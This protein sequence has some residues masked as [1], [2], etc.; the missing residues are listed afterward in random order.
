MILLY[1]FRS[2]SVGV[3]AICSERHA[4]NA[5]AIPR[6]HLS[7]QDCCPDVLVKDKFLK[8]NFGEISE[9][10]PVSIVVRSHLIVPH[11]AH[12]DSRIACN[13][14]A[15]REVLQAPKPSPIFHLFFTIKT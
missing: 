9:A 10:C 12:M 5:E 7:V 4:N 11:V 1:S 13:H 3:R 15:A 6:Q 2:S 8:K 14:S